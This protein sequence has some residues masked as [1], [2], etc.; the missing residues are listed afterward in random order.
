MD[1]GVSTISARIDCHHPSTRYSKKTIPPI[2]IVSN[3]LPIDGN[4]CFGRPS[5]RF[6][7][8]IF[9]EH[10]VGIAQVKL[11]SSH[12]RIIKATIVWTSAVV[13]GA[14]PTSNYQSQIPNRICIPVESF[15]GRHH[16]FSIVGVTRPSCC[17][18]PSATIRVAGSSICQASSVA[19]SVF[20]VGCSG[21]EVD[22]EG[23]CCW[24]CTRFP[25][26]SGRRKFSRR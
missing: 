4:S 23:Q 14:I 22:W 11:R 17:I 13:G 10:K 18:L 3:R 26:W 19:W 21:R 12:K 1:I 7:H 16:S 15:C 9:M 5:R 6:E 8:C 20:A 2:I 24:C 25:T